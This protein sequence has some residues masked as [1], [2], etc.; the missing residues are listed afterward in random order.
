MF[1]LGPYALLK[2]ANR[3]SKAGKLRKQLV[4]SL[5][6]LIIAFGHWLKA[7]QKSIL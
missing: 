6:D 7:R 1:N 3:A 2:L 4:W 5:G